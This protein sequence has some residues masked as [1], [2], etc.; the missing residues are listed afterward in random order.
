MRISYQDNLLVQVKLGI[1][2][3]GHFSGR[4]HLLVT[5]FSVKISKWLQVKAKYKAQNDNE[6][7]VDVGDIVGIMKEADNFSIGQIEV[8]TSNSRVGLISTDM[9]EELTSKISV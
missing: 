7:D 9:L 1:W 8:M 4:K 6:L 3:Y 2:C 5:S